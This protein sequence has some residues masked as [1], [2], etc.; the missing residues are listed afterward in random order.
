MDSQGFQT[1]NG[2][3]MITIT[4]YDKTKKTI[5]GTFYFSIPE[6]LFTPAYSVTDGSFSYVYT[7]LF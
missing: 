5:K 7:I 2:E 3:G 4:E 6:T 1:E